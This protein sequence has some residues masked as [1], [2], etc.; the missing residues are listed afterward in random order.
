MDATAE[1]HSRSN[2]IVARLS[3]SYGGQRVV[4]HPDD[5]ARQIWRTN[6]ELNIQF[7]DQTEVHRW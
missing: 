1:R 2:T 4:N 7:D 5:D 3:D 6:D